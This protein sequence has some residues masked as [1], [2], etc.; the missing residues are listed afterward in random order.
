MGNYRLTHNLPNF[1]CQYKYS[2]IT[3]RQPVHLPKFSSPIAS[4]VMIRQKFLPPKFSLAQYIHVVTLRHD[5]KQLII[6]VMQLVLKWMYP[7]LH[8]RI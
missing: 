6:E 2:G 4:S 8:R 1:P 5:I 3:D 7:W